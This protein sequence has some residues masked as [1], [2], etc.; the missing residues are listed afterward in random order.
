MAAVSWAIK[1]LIEWVLGAFPF[2]VI[3]TSEEQFSIH[4]NNHNRWRN[5]SQVNL[6]FEVWEEVIDNRGTSTTTYT[7]KLFT[8]PGHNIKSP[9]GEMRKTFSYPTNMPGTTQFNE[10]RIFW[11]LNLQVPSLLGIRFSFKEEFTVFRKINLP[12]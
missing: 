4:L 10:A 1:L 12:S 2:K 6:Y 8:S 11:Q 9:R 3:N 5:I 7:K